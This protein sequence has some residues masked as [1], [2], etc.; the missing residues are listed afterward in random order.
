MNSLLRLAAAVVVILGIGGCTTGT[1]PPVP[2][3]DLA[4]SEYVIGPGDKLTVFVWRNPELSVD[5]PV[6]PDGRIS[7][8][9]AD[10]IVAIGKTPSG[11][12]REIEKRLA[13]YVADPIVTV[14]PK[15]FVGPF[16]E[17][18]RV[19]G[20]AV[21]PRA[22]PYRA[23]MTLLD[24]MIE[25]GGLTKYASGNRATL[26]RTV[27]DTQQTYSLHIDSLVKDGEIQS[28]V[29]LIPGDIIIIPQRLF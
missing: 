4:S 24:A 22:L 27:G 5:V 12:G 28:N 20:E 23:N 25:V 26:V 2:P 17:Q 3:S 18:I 29:A 19:I 16:S 15:E 11:L 9:L 1:P 7:I 6:R 10:D 14:L 21:Q 13:K 8:P